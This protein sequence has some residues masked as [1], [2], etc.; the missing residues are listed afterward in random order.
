MIVDLIL[1][2]VGSIVDLSTSLIPRVDSTVMSWVRSAQ[3]GTAN[4]G[5]IP[6]SNALP[7]GP[8]AL[9][10]QIIPSVMVTCWAITWTKRMLSWLRSRGTSSE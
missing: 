6:Y 2:V 3:S 9:M 7:W 1:T 8:L 4:L 5:K 10:A